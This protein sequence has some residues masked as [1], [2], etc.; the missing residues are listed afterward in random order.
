MHYST[1]GLIRY[2]GLRGPEIFS[3][4]GFC[5]LVRIWENSPFSLCGGY[6]A[7]HYETLIHSTRCRVER[8]SGQMLKSRDARISTVGWGKGPSLRST[9][10][11]AALNAKTNCIMWSESHTTPLFSVGICDEVKA[12]ISN[13]K[14]SKWDLPSWK[15]DI[16]QTF[17]H[18]F[19][20]FSLV[21][22]LNATA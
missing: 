18:D 6:H 9:L 12:I 10:L 7:V 22:Q 20:S 19:F 2:R 15:G 16:I 8:V 1:T 11:L 17:S 4:R 5:I 13:E 14:S 21:Q 3:E